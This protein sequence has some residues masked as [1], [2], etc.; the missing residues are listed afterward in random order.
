M[1]AVAGVAAEREQRNAACEPPA[2]SVIWPTT[3][4]HAHK[5]KQLNTP[6]RSRRY[7]RT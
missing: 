1:F 7:P 2:H 5:H 4:F 3:Y 6:R